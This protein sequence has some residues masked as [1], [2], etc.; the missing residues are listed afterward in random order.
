MVEYSCEYKDFHLPPLTLQPIVKN[1]V[2]HGMDPEFAP[3][4][5]SIRTRKTDKES[6]IIVEDDGQGYAPNEGGATSIALINI[7]ERLKIMC[8][9]KLT[10]EPKE[11]GGTIVKVSIPLHLRNSL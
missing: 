5:I 9:G 11:N 10:I 6:E 7:H 3:L 1:A 8:D 4:K 2:K